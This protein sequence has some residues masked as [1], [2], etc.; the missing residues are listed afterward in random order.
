[1]P[2]DVVLKDHADLLLKDLYNFR[3]KLLRELSRPSGNLEEQSNDKFITKLA[4]VQGCIHAAR[5]YLGK[6]I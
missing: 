5:E 4:E 3:E 1:M 6:S 2:F